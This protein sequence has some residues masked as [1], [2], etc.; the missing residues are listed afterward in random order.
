MGVCTVALLEL[1]GNISAVHE[2]LPEIDDPK[3]PLR[4]EES[5]KW[6]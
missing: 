1:R 3:A 2:V 6:R 5:I 4:D